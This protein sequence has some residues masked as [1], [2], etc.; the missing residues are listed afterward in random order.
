MTTNPYLQESL[1]QQRL[2]LDEQMK[3]YQA[4]ALYAA[5][6]ANKAQAAENRGAALDWRSYANPYGV[7]AES[8]AARGLKNSGL[9]QSALSRGYGAYQDRLGKAATARA[10]AQGQI[11]LQLAAQQAQV[12]AAK[13]QAQAD[14]SRQLYEDDWRMRQFD[15]Q[16][17]RDAVADKRAQDEFDYRKLI[18]TRNFDYQQGRDSIGDARYGQEWAYRLNRDSIDDGRYD[19]Q[20]AYQK[21][22]DALMDA[23]YDR[24]W[25]WQT[26][27]GSAP[28]GGS[29]RG[30]KSGL[31]D[32]FIAKFLAENAIQELQKNI[33]KET[34]KERME[35]E[36]RENPGLL[37]I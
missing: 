36:L 11:D 25:A 4:Q 8:I 20:L 16:Q 13:M 18:D 32:A 19:A 2:A 27:K 5:G 30:G 3:Q 29:T 17:G 23:R 6:Q 28:R 1:A 31:S 26:K 33:K 10:E 14:Y 12:D 21:A 34:V 22:R 9:S 7:V 35:R 24:E 37:P 15:Y